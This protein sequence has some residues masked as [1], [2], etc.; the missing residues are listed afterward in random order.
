MEPF[1][2]SIHEEDEEDLSRGP[3]GDAV[4]FIEHCLYLGGRS[5]LVNDGDAIHRA[6]E[7]IAEAFWPDLQDQAQFQYNM[8]TDEIE[9]ETPN[10]YYYIAVR[11]VER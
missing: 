5:P 1:D 9:V 11:A 2:Y 8:E 3:R 6:V 7:L 10:A 4:A